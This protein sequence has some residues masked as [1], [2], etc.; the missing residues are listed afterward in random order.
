MLSQ[1]TFNVFTSITQ[2]F[3]VITDR[4]IPSLCPAIQDNETM[5]MM[6]PFI[7]VILPFHTTTNVTSPLASATGV[8][9]APLEHS[10]KEFYQHPVSAVKSLY[11]SGHKLVWNK[12]ADVSKADVVMQ[13]VGMI[14]SNCNQAQAQLNLY[15]DSTAFKTLEYSYTRSALL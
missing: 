6:S 10:A 1:K 13:L 9:S 3:R 4:E 14:D 11:L 8:S 7:S 2:I 12:L 15:N 5:E